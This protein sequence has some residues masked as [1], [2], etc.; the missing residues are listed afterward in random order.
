M[1]A[2][3]LVHQHLVETMQITHLVLCWMLTIIIQVANISC[4]PLYFLYSVVFDCILVFQCISLYFCISLYLAFHCIFYNISV[5]LSS[6][7]TLN[8]RKTANNGSLRRRQLVAIATN[9]CYQL[10]LITVIMDIHG[11]LEYHSIQWIIMGSL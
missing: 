5:T 9:L 7:A 10:L 4:I 11:Y 2:L 8:L 3:C 1:D 6:S